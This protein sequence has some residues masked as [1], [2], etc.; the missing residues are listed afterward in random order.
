MANQKQFDFYVVFTMILGGRRFCVRYVMKLISTTLVAMYGG[1][2][3]PQQKQNTNSN[4][5]LITT[6]TNSTQ[7]NQIAYSTNKF[8][9]N[10]TKARQYN[11]PHSGFDVNL[12]HVPVADEQVGGF[13]MQVQEGKYKAIQNTFW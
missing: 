8:S 3:L 4:N 11:L 13:W 9:H 6:T 1:P 12:N 10:D 2:Q 7:Q 5:K